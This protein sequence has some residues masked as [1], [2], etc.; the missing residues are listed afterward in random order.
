MRMA[1]RDVTP[2]VHQGVRYEAPH[3]FQSEVVKP[4]ELS[5]R[6]RMLQVLQ[7][8]AD[9]ADAAALF[10]DPLRCREVLEN[11]QFSES[12][13]QHME[14]HLESERVL[15]RVITQSVQELIM[16][17]LSQGGPPNPM[18]AVSPEW[19]L[20]ALERDGTLSAEQRQEAVSRWQASQQALKKGLQSLGAQNGG[21]VL[22]RDE[23]SG[24]VLW[25]LRL[26][27]P[28]EGEDIFLL[29]LAMEGDLLLARDENQREY[30]VDLRQRRVV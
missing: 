20:E 22:A 14:R 10:T 6:E 2:I 26:Y 23:E 15:R 7:Q 28:P 4:P 5:V 30:R 19:L 25:S 29:A 3:F 18:A 13:I 17:S 27:E 11:H 8:S 24:R 12:D 16:K 21:W 1:P 9:P